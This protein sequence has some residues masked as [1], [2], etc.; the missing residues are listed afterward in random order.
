MQEEAWVREAA[1]GWVV[2]SQE[3]PEEFAGAP[4]A[5]L[6][7]HIQGVSLAT[8]SNAPNAVP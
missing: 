1:A 7:R 3:D 8:Q 6:N 4:N 2:L 5:D